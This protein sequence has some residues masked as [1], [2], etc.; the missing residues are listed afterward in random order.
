[1]LDS[2]GQKSYPRYFNKSVCVVVIHIEFSKSY[3][4]SFLSRAIKED[5]Q[6]HSVI[7]QG[8]HLFDYKP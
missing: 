8:C 2:L 7:R 1:L 4:F 6:L 5:G 3:V